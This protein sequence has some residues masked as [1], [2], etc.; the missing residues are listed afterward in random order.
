MAG[1]RVVSSSLLVL[2]T[3][4]SLPHKGGGKENQTA[5]RRE[6]SYHGPIGG[7]VIIE[8]EVQPGLD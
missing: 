1:D 2:I 4:K 3:M 6:P 7:E 5:L 8:D